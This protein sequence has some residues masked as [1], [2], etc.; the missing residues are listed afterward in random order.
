MKRVF[1]RACE[2]M[3]SPT[4]VYSYQEIIKGTYI[5]GT[6]MKAV[7]FNTF[8][9]FGRNINGSKAQNLYIEF[10]LII[11]NALIERLLQIKTRKELS[12]LYDDIFDAVFKLLKDHGIDRLDSYNRI[13]KPIDLY[14][15]HIVLLCSDI[16]KS[17]RDTLIPFLYLPLDGQ[18]FSSVDVFQNNIDLLKYGLNRN[19]T[20]GKLKN[21][22][23]YQGI[24]M[25]VERRAEE[26][27][28]EISYDFY[29]IYF[30]ML[31][32]RQ[33]KKRY[34]TTGT[35]LFLCNYYC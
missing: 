19:S 6:T 15:E 14:I 27:S 9:G 26:I 30:D 33:T 10:M 20:F 5:Y 3:Q 32:R 22:N 1:E 16:D 23:D 24:Q 2:V 7:A 35:N 11:G 13:R 8:Q 12:E 34:E 21:P 29:P 4:P 18:M 25:D 17:Q 28:K 31:W